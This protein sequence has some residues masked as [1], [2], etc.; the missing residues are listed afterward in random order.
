MK[1]GDFVKYSDGCNDRLGT[2]GLVIEVGISYKNQ[3]T[4][5]PVVGVLWE[6]GELENVFGDELG[7]INELVAN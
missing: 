1:V 3:E 4:E 7:I 5:P 2:C 6:T